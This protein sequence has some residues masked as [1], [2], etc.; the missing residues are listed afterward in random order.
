MGQKIGNLKGV[1]RSVISQVSDSDSVQQ[2]IGDLDDVEDVEVSQVKLKEIDIDR[3]SKLA[4]IL[5][6]KTDTRDEGKIAELYKL[7][8]DYTPVESISKE[9]LSE[10]STILSSGTQGVEEIDSVLH[11]LSTSVGFTAGALAIS[12]I[13]DPLHL[14]IAVPVTLFCAG[15][16]NRGML[17]E[18]SL[19]LYEKICLW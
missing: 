5:K 10:A 11:S 3:L 8:A 2:E 17:N 16:L 19:K 14:A 18:L 15:Y 6:K 4:D 7:I 13:S 1:K 9:Q 12:Q